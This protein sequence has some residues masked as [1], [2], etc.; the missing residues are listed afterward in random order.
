MKGAP[1]WPDHSEPLTSTGDEELRSLKQVM[2]LLEKTF[3]AVRLYGRTNQSAQ[4]FLQKLYDGLMAH[5]AAFGALSLDV[6]RYEISCRGKVVY[7][8][9]SQGGSL[10]FKLYT[11]GICGLTFGSGVSFEDL[12]S[13]LG[14]VFCLSS[15]VRGAS[16]GAM[17]RLSYAWRSANTGR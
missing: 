7:Q 15:L 6:Q 12:S 3:N 2:S 11:D 17:V 14:I 1:P 5:L 9:P 16:V 10:A 13:F 4:Q 8:N